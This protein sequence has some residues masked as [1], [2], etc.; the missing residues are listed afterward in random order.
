M[1]THEIRRRYLDFFA[2]QGHLVVPSAPLPMENSEQLFVIAGMVPFV[3][4]FLGEQTPESTRA[5]SIQKCVRTLDIDEVGITTRHNTFFEMAGNFSFGDYFKREAI[6]FAWK[7]LTNSLEEGG[8]AIP[9]DKLWVTVYLEDDQAA[10]IW[11]K[12]VGVSPHRIQRR[13]KK[14]NYWSMGMPGPA[15]PCSEIFYD[16]GPEYGVEGGPEADEDR[17]I[18]IWNL[19]FMEKKRGKGIDKENFEILGDLPRKNIDTGMGIERVAFLLQGVDNVYESDVLRPVI[20]E[21]A[22]VTGKQYGAAS[23]VDRHFR[24]IADHTRTSV[25]LISDGIIPGN[26]GRGYILR[27]MLRRIVRSAKLLG[28]TTGEGVGVREYVQTSINAMKSLYPELVDRQEHIINVAQA[29]ETSFLRTLVAGSKLFEQSAHETIQSGT[30]TISGEKAFVLHDTYGFP[31]DLTLDMARESGLRVDEAGFVRLMEEQKLRAKNDAKSRKVGVADNSVYRDFLDQ[32]ETVFTGYDQLHSQARVIGIIQS[33]QSVV[34]AQSQQ[35]VELIVDKTPFYAESGGQMGDHGWIESTSGLKAR[36]DDV[37][38]IA[39]T[40]W[41]HHTTILEGTV[42]LGD[43]VS[44]HVDP[45]YRHAAAQAHTGTHIIHAALRS[46]LGPQAVQAGSLNRPGYLRFD[47]RWG[48][49]LDERQRTDI[50]ALS[51]AAVDEHHDVITRE[52]DLKAAKDMGAMALFGENYGNSV[53]VVEINGPFSLELC[54]GTHVANSAHIGPIVILGESSVGSG[55]RRVEALVGTEGYNHLAKERALLS[56]IS[57]TLKTPSAQV[58]E[59]IHQLLEKIKES[60]RKI[61]QLQRQAARDQLATTLSHTVPVSGRIVVTEQLPSSTPAGELRGLLSSA[62]KD[63]SEHPAIISLAVVDGGK[64]S[65]IVGVNLLAQEQGLD[66]QHL[67][68]QMLTVVSGKGG[69]NSQI[70][71]GSG[72]QPERLTEAFSICTHQ[73]QTA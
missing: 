14:D 38:K 36:V 58:P 72:T 4:Y 18:E 73:A 70:A 65:L 33:G 16:R 68:T 15:G 53:R 43:T 47:F 9:A 45:Q 41:T 25:M 17:Y 51:H 21:V 6:H 32:G 59:K 30:K 64:V 5:T 19:V 67:L 44:L 69:G 2:Q 55:T 35:S 61:G 56:G 23:E 48:N 71:Q 1:Q 27:R 62:L 66:A 60:E 50:E 26:E 10:E 42:A 49:K 63:C 31:L 54:G 12:E 13:G 20:D 57:E 28:A 39:K 3:P 46:I 7:L 8:F 40:L 11:E 24:V 29:E 52:M 22:R 34:E 37:Q